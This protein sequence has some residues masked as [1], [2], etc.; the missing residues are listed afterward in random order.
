MSRK[1]IAMEIY[2]KM[3]KDR[4]D[5]IDK[6]K[7]KK[8]YNDKFHK[9]E[10]YLITTKK[11][12]NIIKISEIEMIFKKR[13]LEYNPLTDK[14]DGH[15]KYFLDL[16]YRL[17]IEIHSKST[18][19]ETEEKIGRLHKKLN[20]YWEK[21]CYRRNRYRGYNIKMIKRITR[22]EKLMARLRL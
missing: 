22:R 17:A 14:R 6:I 1:R 20:K 15:Y 12:S 18:D 21:M 3:D 7:I 4:Q 10:K 19:K 11:I 2:N 16:Y 5:S 13:Y 8:R 9:I